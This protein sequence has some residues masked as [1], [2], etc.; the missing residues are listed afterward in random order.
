MPTNE[1]RPNTNLA[2]TKADFP[3]L[4]AINDAVAQLADRFAA[5]DISKYPD[6]TDEVIDDLTWHIATVLGVGR[7]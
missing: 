5:W 3:T 2:S 4:Y 1:N 6:K 7:R